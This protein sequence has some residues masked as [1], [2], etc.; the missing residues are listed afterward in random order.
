LYRAQG[1]RSGKSLGGSGRGEEWGITKT[2]TLK[3]GKRDS[4]EG[5]VQDTFLIEREV[6]LRISMRRVAGVES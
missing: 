3:G 4:Q 2:M 5:M 6:T 1:L